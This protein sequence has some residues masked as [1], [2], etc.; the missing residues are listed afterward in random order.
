MAMLDTVATGTTPGSTRASS[1]RLIEPGD[2]KRRWVFKTPHSD[3]LM[4]E[5]IARHAAANGVKKLAFRNSRQEARHRGRRQGELCADRHVGRGPD[6]EADRR[7]A[8]CRGGRR[9]RHP[10][11]HAGPRPART[12]G[13]GQD[14]FQ[15]RRGQ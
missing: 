1:A 10:G 15:P 7:S 5:G 3:S 2:D 11:R 14:L 9:L 12:R 6:P 13:Q 4:A 8:G